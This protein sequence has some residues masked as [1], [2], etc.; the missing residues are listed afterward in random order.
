MAVK[1]LFNIEDY[2]FDY[3]LSS[4]LIELLTKTDKIK[5]DSEYV[6][7]YLGTDEATEDTIKN[8][9][10]VPV[11]TEL[12]QDM[13]QFCDD[14]CKEIETIPGVESA[15]CKS[16]R[17]LGMSTYITVHFVKP[18]NNDRDIQPY[19]KQD[20]KF[21]NHYLGGFGDGN[22]YEGEYKLKF[23]LSNHAVVRATDA[24]FEIDVTDRV[25]N[26]FKDEVIKICKKRVQQLQSYIADFKRTGKISPKQVQRNIERRKRK[27]AYNEVL[28]TMFDKLSLNESISNSQLLRKINRR[29]E[30]CIDKNLQLL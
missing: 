18:T 10:K 4:F 11:F 14:I 13:K 6:N 7:D 15:T 3:D 24:D 23:R 8:Y 1:P 27:A 12:E 21:I 5:K 9:K 17:S 20:R 16:S 25:Y 28:L 19:L 22:G 29:M 26:D 2:E 30:L